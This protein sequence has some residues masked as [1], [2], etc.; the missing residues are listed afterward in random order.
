MKPEGLAWYKSPDSNRTF[1][2]LRVVST[3]AV[4]T[5][6]D[7]TL[8][9]TS[10]NPELMTLLTRCNKVATHFGQPP[11]YQ[12]TQSE[13]ADEA[14]HISIGWTMG[15]PDEETC[16]KVLKFFRLGEFKDIRTWNLEVDGVKAKIGNMVSHLPLVGREKTMTDGAGSIDSLYSV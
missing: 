3:K 1:F 7:R 14:F 2:V 8:P 5:S 13:A 6:S 11:L 10:T 16:L 15:A 9:K 4:K 12:Q